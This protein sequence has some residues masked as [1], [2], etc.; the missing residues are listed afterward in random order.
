MVSPLPCSGRYGLAKESLG[1]VLL[2]SAQPSSLSAVVYQFLVLC[3]FVVSPR[4]W[5][6]FSA[7]NQRTRATLCALCLPPSVFPADLAD[8][9]GTLNISQILEGFNFL[10]HQEKQ[11]LA[12][13]LLALSSLARLILGCSRPLYG[14]MYVFSRSARAGFDDESPSCPWRARV[15]FQQNVPPVPFSVALYSE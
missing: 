6:I 2:R 15:Y 3:F 8:E 4:S 5:F 13:E 9:V 11:R 10:E 1:Q 12:L 7:T 14:Y